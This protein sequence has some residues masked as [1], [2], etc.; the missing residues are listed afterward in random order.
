MTSTTLMAELDW[1]DRN[2]DKY[3]SP[4]H[5]E[6]VKHNIRVN[7]QLRALEAE[8]NRLRGTRRYSNMSR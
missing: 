3:Q 6:D 2:L 7:Y 8:V 5:A 1:I 4:A